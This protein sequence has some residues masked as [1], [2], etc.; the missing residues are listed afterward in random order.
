MTGEYNTRDKVA[1]PT[2]NHN[3]DDILRHVLAPLADLMGAMRRLKLPTL[4]G[5]AEGR[6]GQERKRDVLVFL[7][8][9]QACNNTMHNTLQT[10]CMQYIAGI[11]L[12]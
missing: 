7:K 12:F 6:G 3:R 4:D 10:I 1:N 8:Y 9:L 5:R 2:T 11:Q